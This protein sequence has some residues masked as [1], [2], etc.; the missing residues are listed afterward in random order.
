MHPVLFKL[1]AFELRAYGFMLAISF[2]LGI[3]LA[4]RRGKARGIAA[5]KI[6]DLSVLIIVCSIV[7]SR[8]MY[9][10]FHLDEFA[11]NWSDTF[12]PFQSSGQIGIAGLTML[13]GVILALVASLIYLYVKKMP[14]L[15]FA[16][17][18]I[19]VFFLG[20]AITRIGCFLNGCC[21][22]IPCAGPLCM[23]FPP[24]SPAGAM[25]QGVHIHPAQLYSSAYA[26]IVF[27]ALLLIDRKPRFDGYLLYL[28]L[29]FYGIGRFIID[30]FR[31]YEDSMVI[32]SSLSKGISLNQG[33]S[34]AF[35]VTGGV[36]YFWHRR[37]LDKKGRTERPSKRVK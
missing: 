25:F 13:G 4:V 26:L 34:L 10:L 27:I 11:G 36:L 7:G 33:I 2:L 29:I 3:Y 8:L 23:V 31:Y 35:V 6:M 9:V 5:E 21:Y 14:V 19:P 28:F 20:E 32:L 12:N 30:L 16:D 37:R 18:I 15:K 1:G 22:G 17:A 24:D